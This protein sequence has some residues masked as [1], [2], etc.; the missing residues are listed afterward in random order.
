MNK[1]I[2]IAE[3]KSCDGCTACCS[4][5]KPGEAYGKPFWKGRPCHFVT[6]AG[7]SIYEQRPDDPCKSFECGYKKF[8]WV[9][10]WMRPDRSGVI[11]SIAN[12]N[13][14]EYLEVREVNSVMRADV[15]SFLFIEKLSGRFDNFSYQINGGNNSIG[16]KEFVEAMR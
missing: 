14:I 8:E 16:T 11:L 7:C 4:G 6:D 2:P 3:Y 1:T 9:P 12:K 10:E 13:G 15:L 5:V